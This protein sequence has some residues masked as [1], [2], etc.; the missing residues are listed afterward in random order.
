MSAFLI[1]TIPWGVTLLALTASAAA[2]LRARIIPNRFSI[3]I[4]LCGLALQF[5]LAP[6]QVWIALLAAMTVFGALGV[7]AHF[8]VLGGGDVKLISAA[9]LLVAPD[10]I[11]LLLAE[12]TLAGGLLSAFYLA[13]G[14]VL[15][16]WP[17]LYRRPS[18]TL[19]SGLG[20]W[21]RREGSRAARG[22]P[23]PY[24]LA[25]FCGVTFH[26]MESF[27]HA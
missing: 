5:R 12:I 26:I 25:V 22:Y 20:K 23:V 16:R 6:A 19:G 24:A 21:L 17:Q 9:A 13:A 1:E 8:N 3:L 15:R 7:L 4:A 11:P 14:L 2:D 10:R 18:K 27:H